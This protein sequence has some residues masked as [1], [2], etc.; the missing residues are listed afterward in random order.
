V[1]DE[2]SFDLGFAAWVGRAQHVEEV[3][4]LED[5]RRHVGRGWRQHQCEVV[6][7]LALA[8]VD[9]TVDLQLE[10]GRLQPCFTHCRAYHRRVSTS[11]SL[12][13]RARFW[14]QGKFGNSRCQISGS[15]HAAAKSRM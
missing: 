4:V 11:W 2:R 14:P 15:G 1:R 10:N 7:C 12:S 8:L 13:S 5:L 3:R 9:P 6:L